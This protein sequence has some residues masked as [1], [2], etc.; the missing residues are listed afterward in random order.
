MNAT[1]SSDGN[2]I[3]PPEFRESA[4]LKPG[5]TLDIQ[6]YKGTIVLRKHERLTAEQCAGLLEPSRSRSKPTPED[7]DAV[8]QAIR[9]TRAPRR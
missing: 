6:L 3:I 8:E 1:M 7:E 5:D 9:E 4:H 2:I